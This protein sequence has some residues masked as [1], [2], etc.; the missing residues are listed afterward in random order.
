MMSI[1]FENK[2]FT[3]LFFAGDKQKAFTYQVSNVT[4]THPQVS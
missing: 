4:L 3:I 2:N 1:I